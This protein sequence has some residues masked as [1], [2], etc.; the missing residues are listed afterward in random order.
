[1]SLNEASDERL[2]HALRT[3]RGAPFALLFDRY[4]TGIYNYVLRLVGRQ[5]DA[6]ELTQEV[7]L[8]MLRHC[9]SYRAE[10]S[11]RAWLWGIATNAA[12]DR[13]RRRKTEQ[14]HRNAPPDG[15]FADPPA[16]AT[17][18]PKALALA[19]ERAR[20]VRQ[21]LLRLSEDE[22][23]VVVLRHY[24]GLKFAEIAAM[25]HIPE[26]TAKSRMRYAFEKLERMLKPLM[27]A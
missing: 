6:E 2:I 3:G 13:L 22:R 19:N 10:G 11:F 18:G 14:A 9:T 7:F 17:A 4:R 8:R 25:L 27:S 16:S 26:A 5:E 23:T 1:V 12:R 20:H 15:A 21:A 24:E